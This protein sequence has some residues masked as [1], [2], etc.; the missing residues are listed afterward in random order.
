MSETTEQRKQLTKQLNFESKLVKAESMGILNEFVNLHI[1]SL[2]D[3]P[4][5]S[6]AHHDQRIADM[7]FAT[8]YPLYLAKIEKKGRNEAEL[9]EVIM[10]LTGY[11]EDAVNVHIE[12]KSN[13]S[14]FFAQAKLNPAAKNIKGSI[15]GYKVEEIENPLTQ[16][17]RYLD[18]L[19]DEL[20]KGKSM[21]KLRLKLEK[22]QVSQ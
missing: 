9:L 8:V 13:F 20:A 17:V 5:K 18:K 4:M 22:D 15:C 6:T 2:T 12:N 7:S 16:Q 10:W 19:V 1:T 14:S 21:L 11:D 3:A